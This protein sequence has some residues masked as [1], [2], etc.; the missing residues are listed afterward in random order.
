M[1]DLGWRD[2]PYERLFKVFDTHKSNTVDFKE[3]LVGLSTLRCGRDNR[4]AALK[5]IFQVRLRTLRP[6]AQV[7]VA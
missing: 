7:R 5:L 4:E 3:F 2:L 1:E 6:P